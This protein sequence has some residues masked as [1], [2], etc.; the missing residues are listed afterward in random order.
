M[1]RPYQGRYQGR[2]CVKGYKGY[3]PCVVSTNGPLQ[4]LMLTFDTV[5]LVIDDTVGS[6]FALSH[7]PLDTRLTLRRGYA[8]LS[9]AGITCT[10]YACSILGHFTLVRPPATGVARILKRSRSCSH[11]CSKFLHTAPAQQRRVRTAQ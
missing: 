3:T 5:A 6:C 8:F 9:V 7:L 11:H 10:C 2:R 4:R 1:P